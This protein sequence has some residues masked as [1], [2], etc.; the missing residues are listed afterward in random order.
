MT[1]SQHTSPNSHSRRKMV[2]LARVLVVGNGCRLLWNR[3]DVLVGL[4]N[5]QS[6]GGISPNHADQLSNK[7]HISVSLS[8]L[9]NLSRK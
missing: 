8:S 7:G 6:F 2:L 4:N 5:V 3:N 9:Y 1:S